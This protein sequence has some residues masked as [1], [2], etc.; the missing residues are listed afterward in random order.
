MNH[1]EPKSK[2]KNPHNE[3]SRISKMAFWWIKDLYK[4]GL[5]RPITEDDVYETLETHKSV[6]IADKFAAL[7]QKELERKD[8]SVLR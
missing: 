2:V 1:K 3:A 7:W 8:P 5:K 4:A 6:E